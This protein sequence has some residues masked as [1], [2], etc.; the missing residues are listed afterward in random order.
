MLFRGMLAVLVVA[1]LVARATA[2]APTAPSLA[3]AA[4]FVVLGH[5]AVVN[6][7]ATT[8]IGNVGVSPSSMVEGFSGSMFLAGDVRRNDALA[9]AARA[10]SD[11][12]DAE[13][14][15]RPCTAV[16]ADAALGGKTFLRGVYCFTSADVR[17]NGTVTLDAEG[18]RDAVWIFRFAG[19][20]A[21]GSGAQVLVIGNGY[22]GN[23]FWRTNGAATVGA[24]TL[25]V[26]NVFGASI[27]FG[28]GARLSGRALARGGSVTSNASRLLLCCAPITVAPA[29]LP[30]GTLGTR[31][32]QTFTATGGRTP[33][34][35]R[36]SSGSL[37]AG[38]ALAPGGTL[39]GTPAAAGRFV[40][41]VTAT[42]AV[43]CAGTAAYVV[44]IEGETSAG[45]PALS[46]W[47][48]LLLIAVLTWVGVAVVRRL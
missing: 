27:S 37:P 32:E 41:T 33:Y 9:K 34:T 39:E 18:D 3:D 25:F 12:V 26:G 36:I 31:Y 42:D 48:L 38:L 10:D 35:F 5:S 14:A 22:D 11:T 19:S 17:L 44:E 29:T 20:L 7:G 45:V 1:Q 21:T 43:G 8:V 13:L 23:A 16:L 15:A 28:E 4:S 30:D 24:H 2:S 47:A 46:T 6:T 40:F